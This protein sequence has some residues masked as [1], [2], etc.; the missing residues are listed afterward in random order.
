MRIL[1][2]D[3]YDSFVFNLVHYFSS[4]GVTVDVLSDAQMEPN[5]LAFLSKYSGIVLSPGPGLPEETVSM[6]PIINHCVGR[7]P[8]FGV[9]LGMQGLG[10]SMGGTLVNMSEVRHGVSTQLSFSPEAF[11]FSSLPDFVEVGL[12]HS[13]RIEGLNQ[14]YITSVDDR[15]TVM[16]LASSQRKQ[17]GVQFHPESILTP[18]GKQMISN[19]I[20]HFFAA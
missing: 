17:C 19:V 3:F 10:Q 8:V 5:D 13:W 16:S 7:I 12:Y 15:G 2:V 6:M 14:H 18:H 9:C 20:R 4:L 1:V 11:L